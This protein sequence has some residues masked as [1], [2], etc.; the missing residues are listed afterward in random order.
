MATDPEGL[1]VNLTLMGAD[2]DKFSLSTAGVLS[3]VTAPDR[4]N[5]AD[6]NGDN[7]Y[8]VTVRADEGTMT[9]DR[10]V[11]VTVTNVDEAP[12]ISSGLSVSGL[13]SVNVEEGMTAVSTYTAAGPGSGM[14]TWDVMGDDAEYFTAA[15]GMLMFKIAPNY[16]MPR[17]MAM[18]D[19]NT[20]TYMVTVMATAGDE[21]DS[22]AVEVMVTNVDED[23]VVTVMSES[24]PAV[25]GEDLTASLVDEDGMTGTTW[26]WSRSDAMDGTF[27]DIDGATMMTYTT[28]LDDDGGM[29]LKATASYTDG[30]DDMAETASSDAVMVLA[31]TRP[32]VV[33]QYDADN[34]G[35]IDINEVI[36]AIEA[37]Q[38]DVIDINQVIEV[39]EAYQDGQTAN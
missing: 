6:A 33:R 15:G 35:V 16:E 17:G 34:D 12:M 23:G 29:Y 18:S 30:F 2:A 27:T 13:R 9:A 28:N 32:A 39:I 7:V 14:E 1:N 5:Q 24:D 37:Y 10:M 22:M 8:E 21:M 38:D 3:F 31:D 26:Q 11:R 25:A 20:N 19:T 36:A 4:E